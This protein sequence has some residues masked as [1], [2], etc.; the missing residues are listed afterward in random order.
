MV[1]LYLL[2]SALL[3]LAHFRL[4]IFLPVTFACPGFSNDMLISAALALPVHLYRSSIFP[5]K[6]FSIARL[7]PA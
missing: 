3:R 6:D 7:A 5:L 1:N 2:I 4:R